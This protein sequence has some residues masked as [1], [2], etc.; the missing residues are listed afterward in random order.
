MNGMPVKPRLL[1]TTSGVSSS[2]LPPNANCTSF[3]VM[4]AS[5][6]A[7]RTASAP[8]SSA[9]LSPKRPKGCRPT[10]MMATSSICSSSDRLEGEGHHGAVVVLPE[11]DDHEP[12]HHAEVQF[13]GVGLG[14]A[15]LDPDLVTELD[16]AD[17]VGPKGLLGLAAG[18]GLLG[19]EVLGG[20]RG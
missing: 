19:Q 15:G 14:Q 6:Q 18:V 5:A 9:D 13:L 11:R 20:P 7:A 4:P 3:Q 8:M 10:P 16:E 17:A 1:T 12:D 2:A